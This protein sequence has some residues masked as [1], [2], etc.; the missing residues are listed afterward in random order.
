MHDN[1]EQRI[2]HHNADD[3]S[4]RRNKYSA[5]PF[6]AA[7]LDRVGGAQVADKSEQQHPSDVEGAHR[8]EPEAHGP[9][10]SE[11]KQGEASYEKHH[12]GRNVE[13][14]A[15]LV[16][17]IADDKPEERETC[18]ADEDGNHRAPQQ[19]GRVEGGAE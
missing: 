16:Y 8:V 17:V 14:A 4:C 3:E 12:S 19:V 6:E 13:H 11:G 2:L 7:T 18:P 15:L 10:A 1:E 9:L 5:P